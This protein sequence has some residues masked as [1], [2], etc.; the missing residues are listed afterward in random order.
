MLENK[1]KLY[2]FH[3][4]VIRPMWELFSESVKK[5][6]FELI[7][8]ECPKEYDGAKYGETRYWKLM[9]W[10]GNYRVKLVKDGNGEVIA[11][12]GC[13]SLF[14]EDCVPDLMERIKN[15]DFLAADDRPQDSFLC[16]CLE[17]IRTNSS[18]IK[19]FESIYSDPSIGRG[20]DDPLLNK[21]RNLVKWAALPHNKYWNMCDV[22][23]RLGRPWNM[24]DQITNPPTNIFWFHA[25]FTIGLQ[26][27]LYLMNLVKTLI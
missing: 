24:G 23:S 17:V 10:M 6:S 11:T 21:Y 15:V 1:M 27:K 20:P 4:P 5:T 3:S 22:L 18:C 26:N 13:D 2:T 8:I 16:G 14:F 12:S 9:N 19:L 7:P 25:N